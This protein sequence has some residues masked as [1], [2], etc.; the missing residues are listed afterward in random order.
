MNWSRRSAANSHL[1]RTACAVDGRRF[2][3]HP[4]PALA[5]ISLGNA[6]LRTAATM[7]GADREPDGIRVAMLTIAGL[8][9]AGTAFDPEHRRALL[10]GR[11]C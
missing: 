7:L 8:I 5:T 9:A 2:A 6:A 10:G 11:P 1:L 4:I 3:D